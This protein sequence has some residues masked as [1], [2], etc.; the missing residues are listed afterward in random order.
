MV[1]ILAAVINHMVWFTCGGFEEEDLLG[2]RQHDDAEGAHRFGGYVH[3]GLTVEGR[4]HRVFDVAE[5]AAC[6]LRNKTRSHSRC[7]PKQHT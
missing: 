4:Q 3:G 5:G 1:L 2:L 7:P 6:Q